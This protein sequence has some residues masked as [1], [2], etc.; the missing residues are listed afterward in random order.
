M[1]TSTIYLLGCEVGANGLE[2][3]KKGTL[4]SKLT[5]Q[6]LFRLAKKR[7][8]EYVLFEFKVAKTV[9]QIQAYYREKPKL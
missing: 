2:F 7:A 8:D 5:K 1:V 3:L 9:S 6:G 4:L